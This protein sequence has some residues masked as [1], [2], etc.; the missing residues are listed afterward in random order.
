MKTR[1]RRINI[2]NSTRKDANWKCYLCFFK[3][4]QNKRPLALIWR[5]M[6]IISP[7]MREAKPPLRVCK[8]RK[9]KFHIQLHKSFQNSRQCWFSRDKQKTLGQYKPFSPCAGTLPRK[10]EL[11]HFPR[12]LQM[13]QACAKHIL[14]QSEHGKDVH[15]L[16]DL[17][18]APGSPL[19][20]YCFTYLC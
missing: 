15:C 18:D 13:S 9:M 17:A 5:E 2:W 8:S 1:V 4:L 20:H 16:W 10:G 12:P 11:C 6:E 7:Q 14:L 19:G 3:S